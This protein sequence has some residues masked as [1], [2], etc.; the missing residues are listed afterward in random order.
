M[1]VHQ[2]Y[3]LTHGAANLITEK[4]REMAFNDQF[5]DIWVDTKDQESVPFKLLK[6]AM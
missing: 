5:D 1:S 6:E 2:Q 3:H 4:H